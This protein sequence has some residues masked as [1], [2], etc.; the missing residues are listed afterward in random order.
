MD[1]LNDII[2]RLEQQ[3]KAI[4]T[5]LAALQGVTGGTPAAPVVPAKRPYKRRA[6]TEAK[7]VKAT[8]KSGGISAEGRAKLAEAMKARWALKRAGTTAKKAG[9]K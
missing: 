8:K 1:A 5:A 3:K 6:V 7:P 4:D 9:R 2:A